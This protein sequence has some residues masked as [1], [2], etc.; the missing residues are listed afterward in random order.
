MRICPF[1]ESAVPVDWARS[2][3]LDLE[4]GDLEQQ[5]DAGIA[6]ASLACLPPASPELR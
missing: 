3:A 6:F 4:V 2:T 1:D 5:P